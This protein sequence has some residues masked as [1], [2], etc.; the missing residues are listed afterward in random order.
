MK[1]R[2]KADYNQKNI[3][4]YCRSLGCSV[5]YLH[6]VGEGCPDLLIGILKQNGLIEVK[7]PDQQLSNQKLTNAEQVWHEHWRGNVRIVKT[8]DDALEYVKWL[9]KQS[10][11]D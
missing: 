8:M 10:K 5:Q 4:D 1:Y 7:N 3:A 9:R 11:Y 6:R 2:A